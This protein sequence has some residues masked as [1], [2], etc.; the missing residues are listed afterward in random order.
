MVSIAMDFQVSR[1][2]QASE[3]P[4]ILGIGDFK[5]DISILA[6]NQHPRID[7]TATLTF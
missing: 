7:N 3:F 2:E 5:A 4:S 1:D 6:T